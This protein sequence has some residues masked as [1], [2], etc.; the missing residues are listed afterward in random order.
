[1]NLPRIGTLQIVWE[2]AP[3]GANSQPACGFIA[4]T[5]YSNKPYIYVQ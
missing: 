2:L 1:M 5:I 3:Y 4:H